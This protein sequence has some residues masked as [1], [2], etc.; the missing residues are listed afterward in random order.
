MRRIV[1][2][3]SRNPRIFHAWQANARFALTGSQPIEQPDCPAA[4]VAGVPAGVFD[5]NKI[6]TRLYVDSALLNPETSAFV[7]YL[8]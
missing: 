7:A 8:S 2:N 5:V 1:S 6:G 3:A 4:L